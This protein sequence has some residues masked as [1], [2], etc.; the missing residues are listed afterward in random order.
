MTPERHV[1]LTDDKRREVLADPA[2][3]VLPNGPAYDFLIAL[4]VGG[5]EGEDWRIVAE[6][7]TREKTTT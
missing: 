1:L 3:G 5:V 2:L 6:R 7:E 4:D